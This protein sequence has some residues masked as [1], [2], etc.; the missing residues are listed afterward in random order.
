MSRFEEGN[1]LTYSKVTCPQHVHLCCC[2]CLRGVV[3]SKADLLCLFE[4]LLT[5]AVIKAVES[6]CSCLK[7]FAV[8]QM[9]RYRK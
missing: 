9:A 3:H 5:M 4:Q 2:A 8:T 7:L 1:T 6:R